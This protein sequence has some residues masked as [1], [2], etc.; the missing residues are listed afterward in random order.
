[1]LFVE[2]FLRLATARSLHQ[3]SSFLPILFPSLAF[4]GYILCCYRRMRCLWG[5]RMA[6]G[7]T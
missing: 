6:L 3:K 7:M 1:M 5:G 4:L 2:R